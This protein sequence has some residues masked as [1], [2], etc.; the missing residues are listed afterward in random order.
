MPGLEPL[1][2]DYSI[3]SISRKVQAL[4][5]RRTSALDDALQVVDDNTGHAQ[6]RMAGLSLEGLAGELSAQGAAMHHLDPARIADLISD[7]FED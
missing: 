2:L 6:A 3:D 7:P 4:R 1:N 5:E